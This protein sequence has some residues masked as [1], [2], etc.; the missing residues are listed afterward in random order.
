LKPHFLPG[1]R[2]EP[3]RDLAGP[4]SKDFLNALDFENILHGF[5]PKSY[6]S[7]NLT[8]L[9]A[10]PLLMRTGRICPSGLNATGSR[11]A[12]EFRRNGVSGSLR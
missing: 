4:F 9:S 8:R 6:F 1:W 2:I 11:K 3:C 10:K 5:V 12:A 7:S